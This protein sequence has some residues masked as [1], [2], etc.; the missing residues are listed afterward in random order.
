[1]LLYKDVPWTPDS[2]SL[3]VMKGRV[4]AG[5]LLDAAAN[6]LWCVPIDG[7]AARR[8]DV[9][10]TR[11]MMGGIGRIRLHPDGRRLTYVSG[12]YP[13]GE[14][15]ALENFLPVPGANKP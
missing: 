5:G 9:D 6:E 4:A 15:W 2:R 10:A 14:V 13:V 1:M 12:R 3:I 11:V 7:T 8:L